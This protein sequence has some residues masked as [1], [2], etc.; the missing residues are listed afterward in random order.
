M[1]TP[2]LLD[3]DSLL[4][5]IPGDDPAGPS[6]PY[7]VDHE[8]KEARKE[9]NPED[10]APNDPMRPA[11]F[12]KADWKGLASLAE[13][14]LR[15]KSK[16]LMVAARLT[17]ALVKLHGFAGLRDGL[18][19]LR[20]LVD[21]CWDRMRP[22]IEDGDLEVRATPFFWLDDPDKGSRFPTTIRRVPFLSGPEGQFG[23][24]EWRQSQ[25]GKGAVTREAFEQAVAT[26]SAE[27]VAEAA[28]ALKESR[29]ELMLLGQSLGTRM[30]PAAPGLTGMQR[31]V[32]ECH[33]LLQEVVK[34]KGPPQG[35]EP[36]GESPK[37]DGA[38]P[39]TAGAPA[40]RAEAYRQ[41]AQAA[42]LLQQLEPHSPIPYLVRRAVELG[43]LPFPQL[44][45]ALIRDANVLGELNREL[46]IKAG[47]E[48][49]GGGSW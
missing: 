10:F 45:K 42:D 1:P 6:V 38:V 43:A 5:P 28:E 22:V 29:Q 46:G 12:K 9:D 25:D 34:R 48:P 26:T 23:W 27:S 16:D 3:I 17:E 11:E 21:Q 8:L 30:G 2:P 37:K 32:E 35:T 49:G 15:E 24:L 7:E 20:A 14:T 36:E 19:L 44:I 13:Q 41:L 47:E 39:R 31:V 33:Q 4:A 18:R 40:T